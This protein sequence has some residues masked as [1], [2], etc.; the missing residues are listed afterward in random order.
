MS[1]A[2]EWWLAFGP[3]YEGFVA[4]SKRG[5]KTPLDDLPD[6]GARLLPYW[7]A[8][9]DCIGQRTPDGHLCYVAF[10]TYLDFQGVDDF[11]QRS[12]YLFY[13]R[14]MDTAYRSWQ[15]KK[16]NTTLGKPK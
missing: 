4:A 1:A 6:V 10:A 2:L 8:Y 14:H 11:A 9:L 5:M 7:Q 15:S 3:D 16:M 12:I 13:A